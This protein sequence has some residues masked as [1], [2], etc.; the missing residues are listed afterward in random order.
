MSAVLIDL[1]RLDKHFFTL[2]QPAKKGLCIKQR[3]TGI[4]TCRSALSSLLTSMNRIFGFAGQAGVS[5][6]VRHGVWKGDISSFMDNTVGSLFS[7]IFAKFTAMVNYCTAELKEQAQQ[8][9]KAGGLNSTDIIIVT[10]HWGNICVCVYMY[11][12]ER[13][14]GLQTPLPS[15]ELARAGQLFWV[16]PTSKSVSKHPVLLQ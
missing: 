15:L 11:I 4:N 3:I 1:K 16:L 5:T 6:S 8:T 12:Y 9:S 2:V 14:H 7:S 10:E 13:L